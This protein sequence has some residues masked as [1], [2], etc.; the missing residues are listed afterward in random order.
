MKDKKIVVVT[1]KLKGRLK[2]NTIRKLVESDNSTDES[3]EKII[4]DDESDNEGT[5]NAECLFSQA[6]TL[7]MYM[8][9]NELSV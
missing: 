7:K 3:K 9:N 8:V 1:K 2:R 5:S 4:L 6:S